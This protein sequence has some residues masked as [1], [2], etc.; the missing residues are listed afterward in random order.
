[1]ADRYF[2]STGSA[3]GN[4]SQAM[5]YDF[6][7]AYTAAA[8]GD[9]LIGDGDISGAQMS[10]GG[11]GFVFMGKQLEIVSRREYSCRFI[12][13]SAS[14]F[15]RT[16]TTYNLQTTLGD[17]IISGADAGGLTPSE[18]FYVP[19]TVSHSIVLNGTRI[20]SPSPSLIQLNTGV[21]CSLTLTD[22]QAVLATAGQYFVRGLGLASGTNINIVRPYVRMPNK[23]TLGRLIYLSAAAA[24][25]VTVDISEMDLEATS[26]V[27]SGDHGGVWVL[28]VNGA[29]VRGGRGVFKGTNAGS[30]VYGVGLDCDNASYTAHKCS[31]EKLKLS[32]DAAGGGIAAIIG[33]DGTGVGDNLCN[34]GLISEVDATGTAQFKS[35][36]GHGLMMG[37]NT[38]SRIEG[39]KSTT[40]AMGALTK[41]TTD[42][43]IAGV[44]IRDFRYYAVY[45]KSTTR[46]HGHNNKIWQGAGDGV[47]FQADAVGGG[48][49]NTGCT[50]GGNDINISGNVGKI[51]NTT[52][53]QGVDIGPNRFWVNTGAVVPNPAATILGT[54]YATLASANAASDLGATVTANSM[55]PQGD[56]RG[57]RSWLGAEGWIAPPL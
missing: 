16:G 23:A 32:V 54:D 45:Y 49:D 3:A 51:F 28:N 27:S 6:P 40:M 12:C 19:S 39:G 34:N 50:F 11:A 53:S 43:S 41:G 9:R 5:P 47:A 8:N 18:L 36:D 25:G 21:V 55:I 37:W 30:K 1:M 26:S 17:V 46:T 15:L 29:K 52:A 31:I 38:G 4:G 20:T 57:S 14:Y 44:E 7:S 33:H 22:V 10:V 56:N 48:A 35:G 2:S 42:C 24:S 13:N